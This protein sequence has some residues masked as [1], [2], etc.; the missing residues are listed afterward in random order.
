MSDFLLRLGQNQ[1]ARRLIKG[2]GLPVPMPAQ[3]D[4]ASG[5]ETEH[6]LKGETI[7]LSASG[8]TRGKGDGR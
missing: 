6:P 5:P 8:G 4:R 7:V 1:G 2:L 3:L